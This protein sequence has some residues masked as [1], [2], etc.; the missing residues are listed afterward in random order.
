MLLEIELLSL[1][2][3]IDRKPIVAKAY[4]TLFKGAFCL[5]GRLFLIDI[6]LSHDSLNIP[7]EQ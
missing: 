7:E 5:E 1:M 6:L 2:V 3:N 4:P